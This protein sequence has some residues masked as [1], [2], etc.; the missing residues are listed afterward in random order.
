M[1]PTRRCIDRRRKTK[2]GE[3][4]LSNSAGSKD[5]NWRNSWR[6]KIKNGG[7]DLSA[8]KTSPARAQDF[9][10]GPVPE[11]QQTRNRSNSDLEKSKT[12][13]P[14]KDPKK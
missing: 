5:F 9:N 7:E 12:A 8:T 11:Q 14:N 1:K 3:R 6:D 2:T 13:Q 4:Q 10:T